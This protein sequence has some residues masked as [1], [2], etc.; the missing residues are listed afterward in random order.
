[1]RR[2]ILAL[3]LALLIPGGVYA[4]NGA[5]S[6]EF[7]EKVG[8]YD[9]QFL[10]MP[11]GARATAMGGAF[12]AVADDATSVFWNPAGIARLQGTTLSVNHLNWVADVNLTQGTYVFSLGFLP[13]MLAFNARSLY[14][15]DLKR[16]TVFRPDGDGTFFDAGY[17]AFGL[18]YAR[19]LTDKFSVGVTGSVVHAGLDDLSSNVLSFDVGTLYDTGFRSLKIGMSIQNMGAGELSYVEDTQAA[20]LPIL[21]RVGA[22]INVLNSLEHRVVTSAEFSHPPDNAERL[23]WGGEYR[24]KDFFFLRGGMNF[25]YD[26]E[27]VT[28]GVG[29][30]FPT[31]ISAE[32][33]FDYSYTDLSD[34]AGAHRF[35]LEIGF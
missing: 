2:L 19:S 33:R 26:A 15:D 13:G 14:M 23:N 10:K 11:I 1:M 29:V 6:A 30:Q 27:G 22:S 17:S 4:P 32:T 34:L 24:F 28:G 16:T 35:S 21:F 7:F 25:G 9:G 31:S 20:K 12:V 8:T 3:T 5:E 18:T